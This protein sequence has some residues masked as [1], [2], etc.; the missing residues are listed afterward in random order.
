MYHTYGDDDVDERR[1]RSRTQCTSA[2]KFILNKNLNA[3]KKQTV[4]SQ[5]SAV[6]T[7]NLSW[8]LIRLKLL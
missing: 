8:K 4:L 6:S 1:R 3:K 7:L 5:S 2:K